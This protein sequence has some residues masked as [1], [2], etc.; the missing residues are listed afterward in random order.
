MAHTFQKLRDELRADPDAAPYLEQERLAMRDALVLADLRER[1]ATRRQ[2]DAGVTEE[3]ALDVTNIEHEEDAYLATLSRYIEVLGGHLE[4]TAVFPDQSIRL[5]PATSGS[6]SVRKPYP[7][8]TM[9][10]G[11]EITQSTVCQSSRVDRPIPRVP[12]LSGP[13][14]AM[15]GC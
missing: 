15:A 8:V 6:L 3:D 4:V 2:R 9:N 7:T 13:A 11:N 14:H 1:R 12:R 10:F 5:V